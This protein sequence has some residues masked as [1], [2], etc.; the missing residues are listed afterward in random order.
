MNRKFNYYERKRN[1]IVKKYIF[2][3]DNSQGIFTKV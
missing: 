3:K 1:Q 2:M